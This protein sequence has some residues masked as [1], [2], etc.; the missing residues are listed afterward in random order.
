VHRSG[1]NRF[2]MATGVIAA[3]VGAGVLAGWA[4]EI[5]FFKNI[6][7][8]ATKMAAST[9][10]CF[11]VAGM[12]LWIAASS[13][14]PWIGRPR[15]VQGWLALSGAGF[16]A[17]IGALKLLEYWTG[18]SIGL[19]TLFFNEG[20][21][22][23]PAR[24]APAT[25]F[26]FLLFGIAIGCARSR[27]LG[28]FQALALLG[29]LVSWLGLSQY[30]YGGTPLFSL[31]Q[32]AVHTAAAFFLLNA[33]MLGLRPDRGLVGLLSSGSPGGLMARRLVPAALFVP[34]I[35]GWVRLAAQREG[36]IGTEAGVSLFAICNIVI[37]GGLIWMSAAL[38]DRTDTERSRAEGRVH[39]QLERLS[40]LQQITR[41]IGERQDTD[42]I[43]QA[44]IQR[45]EDHLPM[46]FC[47]VLLH[48]GVSSDLAVAAVGRKSA[49]LAT[50]LALSPG[51]Q[52]T[53]GENGLSQ[54]IRGQ[55]V[56]EPDTS[57]VQFPFPQ[58]LASLGL[59]A[60]VATPLLVESQVFGLLLVVRRE[61]ESF[62][63]AECEFLKQLSE[64]VALAAH[65][66]DLHSALKKAY[67]DLRTTQ[68]AI[69][70]QERLRALGQ[71]A[72]GIAH[73]INNAIAPVALYTEMLLEREPNLSTRTREY[74]EIT[75][76]AIGD[77]S[78]TIS[79]MGEFYRQR[80]PSLQ[81]EPTDL[82]RLVRQVLDLTRARWTD[83]PQQRGFVIEVRQELSQDLPA[84]AA[85]ES[86]IREALTN[87]VFNA[88]DAMPDG[89]TLTIRTGSTP[90]SAKSGG[91]V[92]LE[93]TDSG[94]GMDEEARRRCLEPFFTTKG[95]RGTG[96]GLAMV[97]G[98]VRRHNA[99]LEIESA[100]GKGTTIRMVFPISA[101]GETAHPVGAGGLPSCRNI[102]LVDDDPLLI[103]SL[104]DALEQDGHTVVAANGG[105]EGIDTFRAAEQT[106]GRFAVVITDLGMPYVD[107]R[108]VAS[109]VKAAS[110]S[111]PVIL[112]T[113]WG[114]RLVAEADIPAHV[115][116]VLSKP[117]K[118]RE[119]RE[120]LNRVAAQVG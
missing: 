116:Y 113:G 32:M 80:K 54:C 88:V 14:T 58:R 4:F 41:A 110:P 21:V 49:S 6:L 53:I 44:M 75:Q 31:A 39:A 87:L 40:L 8:G 120:A 46:D 65:Q 30:L 9:A 35:L 16:V 15:T 119:L 11:I 36:L 47:S 3:L 26:D 22:R 81:L 74:L 97:Y 50:E 117:P 67:D 86:E 12:S 72:S 1:A 83:M 63:S 62:S 69:L 92:R 101:T 27:F 5:S 38:L 19:D 79:R 102:L 114:Q 66:R 42:S 105:Q 99:D 56:Y 64:H 106:P 20:A 24:M 71:M 48:D 55:L 100:V 107:G 85:M 61:P 45:L 108:K 28:I 94:L 2:A 18:K 73:D 98:I 23:Q 17:L 104:R 96:L 76:R 29:G 52:I 34:A 118:L 25:A 43:F 95:E 89:G 91:T 70:Q 68:D 109:A 82:N 84:V 37:F 7:P 78:H 59:R 103:K 111:T 10:V 51:T 33:G 93:I 13:Q 77:V 112:L 57:R 60:L 90:G 115:D